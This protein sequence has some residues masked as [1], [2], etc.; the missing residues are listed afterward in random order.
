MA[1]MINTNKALARKGLMEENI[2]ETAKCRHVARN[3]DLWPVL[4]V[5][6]TD[7]CV[8]HKAAHLLAR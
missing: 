4:K 6:V 2:W 8:L 3:R 5:L 1:E 7:I